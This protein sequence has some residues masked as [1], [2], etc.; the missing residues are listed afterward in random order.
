[1]TRKLR[2]LVLS[3]L[4]FGLVLGAASSQ[5]AMAQSYAPRQ[6]YS[7]WQKPVKTEYYVRKYYSKPT[8]EYVGYR[9]HEVHYYPKKPKYYYYYN[10]KTKKYW[11]RCPTEGDGTP[12]YSL[13]K[14]EDRHADLNK[15]P[16]SA[17]PEPG[18]M[19]PIPDSN[20]NEGAVLDLPPEDAPA[21]PI[22]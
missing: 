8:P 6:Y 14:M 1:M 19:P 15:I 5:S 18:E 13:L 3:G 20:P 22:P 12:Q 9:T 4:T 11:G 16:E 7:D 2:N 21:F 10:T 17:F